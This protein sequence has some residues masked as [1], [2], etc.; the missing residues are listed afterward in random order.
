M[1]LI[2]IFCIG[3]FFVTSL[4]TGCATFT[5]AG[6]EQNHS[7]AEDEAAET[8][9]ESQRRGE[10]VVLIHGMMR[11]PQS[12]KSMETFLKNEGYDV[13]NWGYSST[14]CSIAELGEKLQTDLA[15]YRETHPG[16]VNFVAHSLGNII[17]R[18]A[19]T[20]GTPPEEVGRVVMLAPPNHGSTMADTFTPIIGEIIKPIAELQT[21]AESTANSLPEVKTA[22]IGIIAGEY[23][24]KVS[25]EESHL[26]EESDHIVVPAFHSFLMWRDD[27]KQQVLTFLEQGQFEHENDE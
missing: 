22:E 9:T 23:D 19:L 27:V 15:E 16:K 8:S 24:D 2:P 20:Q 6:A 21:D 25:I 7:V 14:C 3:S 17:T 26:E 13:F 12:M 5:L 4:V 11:S 18:W 10:I 1:K